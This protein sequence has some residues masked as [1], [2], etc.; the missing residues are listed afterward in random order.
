M[1]KNEVIDTVVSVAKEVVKD[2]L[3]YASVGMVVMRGL[4]E[5]SKAKDYFDKK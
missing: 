4:K 3:V 5:I 1:R 2:G